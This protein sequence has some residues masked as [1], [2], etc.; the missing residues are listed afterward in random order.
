MS[1]EKIAKKEG[2]YVNSSFYKKHNGILIDE[3][4]DVLEKTME[5]YY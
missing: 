1:D 2:D 3:N 5:N 4:A